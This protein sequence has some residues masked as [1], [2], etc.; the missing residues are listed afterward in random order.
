MLGDRVGWRRWFAIGDRAGRTPCSSQSRARAHSTSGR[1]SGLAAAFFSA[2]RDLGNPAHRPRR[3]PSLVVGLYG[4]VA[5]TA[6]TE[7]AIGRHRA[8]GH[9]QRP[10]QWLG[11]RDRRR[12]S[13][14]SGPISR[15]TPSAASR[16]R[17]SRRSATRCCCWT[18]IAGYV[19]FGEVPDRLGTCRCRPDRP[20]RPL[21]SA[22]RGCTPRN[23]A[24]PAVS[25]GLSATNFR[26]TLGTRFGLI[27]RAGRAL[28]R[29]G[30]TAAC[31]HKLWGRQADWLLRLSRAI[32]WLNDQFGRFANWTG[33]VRTA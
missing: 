8:M 14:A 7:L 1:L 25:P 5:V 20:E 17:R 24:T 23:L 19:V 27:L 10:G 6:G 18:G 30:R 28:G 9:A 11:H 12:P 32:D 21:C 22:P 16:S 2:G 15:S 13:L 33:A 26:L 4:T 3:V 29:E 31:S